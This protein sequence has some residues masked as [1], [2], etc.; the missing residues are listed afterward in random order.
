MLRGLV[1]C[2]DSGSLDPSNPFNLLNRFF[3]LGLVG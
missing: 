2:T 3:N 1:G